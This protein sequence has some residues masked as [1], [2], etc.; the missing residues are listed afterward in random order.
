MLQYLLD[1]SWNN[2]YEKVIL[3]LNACSVVVKSDFVLNFACVVLMAAAL[4]KS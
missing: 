3:I 2:K 4:L 1:Q